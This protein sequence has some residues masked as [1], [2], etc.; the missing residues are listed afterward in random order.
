[1]VV[2]Q[3]GPVHKNMVVDCFLVTKAMGQTVFQTRLIIAHHMR[4]VI[5]DPA[6]V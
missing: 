2:Y 5:V 6:I 4:H 3:N 1:M